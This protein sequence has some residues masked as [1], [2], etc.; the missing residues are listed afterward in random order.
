MEQ[1]GYTGAQMHAELRP[2]HL[3]KN[4]IEEIKG[5]STRIAET[6]STES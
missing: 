3:L 4:L 5:H 2:E 6:L 1:S